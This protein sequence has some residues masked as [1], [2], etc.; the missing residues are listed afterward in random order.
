MSAVDEEQVA[1][2]GRRR[3]RWRSRSPPRRDRPGRRPGPSRRRRRRA[4]SGRGRRRGRR[5]RGRWPGGRHR[6]PCRA[7]RRG[8]AARRP[9]TPAPRRSRRRPGRRRSRRCSGCRGRG[10]RR[11]R[12]PMRSTA[13][14]A[15][16]AMRDICASRLSRSTRS[17]DT[18]TGAGAGE[19]DAEQPSDRRDEVVSVAVRVERRR[20]RTIAT[21][22]TNRVL[23]GPAN[24]AARKAGAVRRPTTCGPAPSLRSMTT[25]ER[26]ERQRGE[27][28]PRG[29]RG[30]RP[31]RGTTAGSVLGSL[32][33]GDSPTPLAA[34][35]RRWACRR[36]RRVE[37]CR[38]HDGPDPG[39]PVTEPT[40]TDDR[41]RRRTRLT[42]GRRGRARAPA[43]LVR[44]AH[45]G[46]GASCSCSPWRSSAAPSA[47]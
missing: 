1:A 39:G 46:A 2:V 19:H 44:S 9:C 12:A 36:A 16:S 41:P 11:A 30:P 3:A 17:D 33:M 29:A 37:R 23:R 27:R 40:T 45:L 13:S 26:D 24:I 10:S 18:Q 25:I 21:M 8:R 35:V 5:R 6:R 32:G 4:P 28:R 38:C 34:S 43:A 22:A 15:S 47:T 20:R 31:A 14:W 42:G 7:R